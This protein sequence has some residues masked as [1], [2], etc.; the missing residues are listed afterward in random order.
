M[1]AV[2]NAGNET[3]LIL[4]VDDSFDRLQLLHTA[5]LEAGFAR[6]RLLNETTD[7]L[8]KVVALRPDVILMEVDSP[9]RDVLEQ[10]NQV[11]DRQ[12]TAVLMVSQD[13][14]A[15]SIQAA[16]ASGVC[17]YS[18]DGVSAEKVRPAVEVAMATFDSFRKLRIE[19]AEA[20]SKLS[21]HKR[22]DRAKHILIEKKGMTEDEAHKALR[23]LSMDRKRKLVDVAD[24][25]IALSDLFQN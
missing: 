17:A 7:L 13:P 2:V 19:L 4:A 10:L 6:I 20:K 9:S 12:P 8:Q 5:L 16:V 11:R 18:V 14:Q 24:D 25:L 21:Q 15:Q 23:K 1:R 3:P 22:I